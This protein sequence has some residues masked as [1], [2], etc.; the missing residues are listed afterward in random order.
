MKNR[1]LLVITGVF[2]VL[3]LLIGACALGFSASRLIERLPVASI[4]DS[5]TDTVNNALSTSPAENSDQ[6]ANEPLVV[7]KAS[8][9]DVEPA[10]ADQPEATATPELTREELFEPF[11]Q[12]WDLAHEQFVDQPVDEVVMMR[13]AIKGMLEALG[14]PHTSYLDPVQFE[15]SNSHL[16]GEEY[17]GIGAWVDVSGDFLTIISPMPDSPAEQAGLKPGDQV[18]AV[19]GEDMTGIDG[20]AVRDR[21]VG[22]RGT[23]V[24]LTIRRKG[25]EEPFEVPVTRAN[26]IVPS[27]ESKMME[28]DIAYV[29]LLVFGDDTTKDLREALKEL[30]KN[31]PKGLILDLRYN[32]GGYRDTAIEVGSE[33]IKDGVIMYQEFGDGKRDTYESNG[34]GLA[35]DIPMVVLINEGSASA[36]EIVGGAIQDRERG[37]LIGT[38]SYG[39]G[40]VQVYTPLINDQG[41][42]RITVARWL[43]PSGGTVAGVGLTPDVVVEITDDDVNQGR[44]PQL[45]KA[46]ELLSGK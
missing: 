24:V 32:G 7:D 14:D 38:Q 5:I 19:D 17:E 21:V 42:V 34:K 15:E 35:T 45:D 27:V 36:S 18:I 22:P 1:P 13:G 33:F 4:T 44:D 37:Q 11:W 8:G 46:I 26:I 39:K 25:V 28:N 31:N 2:V 29:R 30:M 40:T 43:T 23:Q 20:L 16:E 3:L 41:A 10:I 12:A 6:S 9:N